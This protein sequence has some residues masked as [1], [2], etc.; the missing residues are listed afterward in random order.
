MYEVSLELFRSRGYDNTTVEEIARQTGVSKGTFFNYFETKEHVIR[1]WYRRMTLDGL[2]R[3]D[4]RAFESARSAIL[5]LIDALA[6]GAQAEPQ[7]CAA[8]VRSSIVSP[9]LG[10]EEKQLD[11]RLQA[12]FEKHLQEGKRRGEIDPAVDLALVAATVLATLSG[13]A[14][15]WQLAGHSFDLCATAVERA[16]LVLR[17]IGPLSKET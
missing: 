4:S 6:R 5:G 13:T 15:E 3:A 16:G 9:L 12:Y 2:A 17:A 7:L 14:R 11:D 10:V 8:K 1:Q